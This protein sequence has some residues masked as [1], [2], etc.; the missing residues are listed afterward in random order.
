MRIKPAVAIA[1]ILAATALT[2][3]ISTASQP[4]DYT[5]ETV[6]SQEE[7]YEDMPCFDC[8]EDGNLICGPQS[9]DEVA[10]AW[11]VWDYSD[12]PRKLKVDT[13]RAF[14]VDYVGSAH[15]TP[16][17]LTDTEVALVGKDGNWYVFRA[18]SD[19]GH[20]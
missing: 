17:D 13:S 10:T 2:F 16:K 14:R 19:I 3:Q 20:A 4:A 11:E 9:D 1:S 7:C 5:P 8:Y 12:G 6:T 15:H 18:V